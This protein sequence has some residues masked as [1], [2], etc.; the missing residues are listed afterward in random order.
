M[1][2]W[3][4]VLMVGLF[5]GTWSRAVFAAPVT[6]SGDIVSLSCY[7]ENHKNIGKAGM[8]CANATVKYI[9]DPVGLVATDGTVYQ[10]EGPILGVNN[11]KAVP[12]LGHKVTIT[13][14]VRV[15][16][17]MTMLNASEAKI[18]D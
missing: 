8:L 3:M 7:Y 6:V 15:K 2:K 11:D 4:V 12:L 9:G 1:K 5:V 17:H 18:T 10:L 16:A 13:G 14:E